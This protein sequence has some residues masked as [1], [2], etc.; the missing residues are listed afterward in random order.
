ME[1]FQID[2]IAMTSRN[3]VTLDTLVSRPTSEEY[4]DNWATVFAR[5]EVEGQR[6]QPD[7]L[8]LIKKALEY[9]VQRV[10]KHLIDPDLGYDAEPTLMLLHLQHR[11]LKRR[12]G[13]TLDKHGQPD[14]PVAEM[15]L[16]FFNTLKAECGETKRFEYSPEVAVRR[17]QIKATDIRDPAWGDASELFEATIYYRPR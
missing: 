8:M 4:R 2:L 16:E 14:F 9:E 10:V 1:T 13:S 12:A 3:D 15:T 5:G 17:V 7:P 11:A 6:Q